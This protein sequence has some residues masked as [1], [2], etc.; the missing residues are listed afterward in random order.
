MKRAFVELSIAFDGLQ[1]CIFLIPSLKTPIQH[2]ECIRHV[3]GS[4][5]N[6]FHPPLSYDLIVRLVFT[7]SIYQDFRGM[8]PIITFDARCFHC[9]RIR[10]KKSLRTSIWKVAFDPP[11]RTK[12]GFFMHA[13]RQLHPKRS[14][15]SV[16][17]LLLW[18]KYQRKIQL[19]EFRLSTTFLPIKSWWYQLH[20]FAT[21]LRYSRIR[22]RLNFAS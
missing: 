13:F 22:N 18:I 2:F 12:E 11:I 8:R 3:N 10:M 14:I 7:L 5:C 1:S 9:F 17:M 20:G 16:E 4:S 21:S 15:S 6:A 19:F